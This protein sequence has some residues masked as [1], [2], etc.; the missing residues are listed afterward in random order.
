MAAAIHTVV[1]V[2]SVTSLIR[3]AV[4]YARKK[5]GLTQIH[6]LASCSFNEKFTAVLEELTSGK[7]DKVIDNFFKFRSKLGDAIDF[8][9]DGDPDSLE[10]RLY[11]FARQY[12]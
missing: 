4:D 12:C 6:N 9:F 11:G 7:Y 10:G 3:I 1:A 5:K 8:K 2:N